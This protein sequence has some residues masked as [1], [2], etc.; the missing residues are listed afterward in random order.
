[1]LFV[2]T[3]YSEMFAVIKLLLCAPV[4]ECW[5]I[6]EITGRRDAKSDTV[7]SALLIQICNC[8][9]EVK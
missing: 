1:M 5:I 9:L 8:K 7:M 6:R 3:Y 2:V 4:A